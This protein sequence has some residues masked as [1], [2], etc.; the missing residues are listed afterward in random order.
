MIP[1]SLFRVSSSFQ[2]TETA[3]EIQLS[4]FLKEGLGQECSIL[5]TAHSRLLHEF[6]HW[7]EELLLRHDRN[8]RDFVRV[9]WLHLAARF[10]CEEDQ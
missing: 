4:Y 7:T 3:L 8:A 2:V 10:V 9:N 6:G 5:E 1:H